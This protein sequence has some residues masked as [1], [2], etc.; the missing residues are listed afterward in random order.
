MTDRSEQAG[1]HGPVPGAERHREAEERRIVPP[2]PSTIDLHAHTSR[3]DGLLLPAELARQAAAVGVRL[4]AITDH[5]TLAGV[6]ELRDS[7]L[8]PAGLEILPG[9][10]INGVVRDRPELMESEVHVLGLGVNPDH[11]GLEAVLGQQRQARR[12]RFERM[13][14]R[15][16]DLG[17]AIDRALEALPATDEDDALGRPRLAR[18][19][20]A[21]DAATSVGDAFE[22]WLSRGRPAYVPRTGLSPIEA[23][24]AIRGAG[25]LPSLAHFAEAPSL[26]GVIEELRA[27]GLGGLEVYHRS[28]D[29]AT[30]EAVGQVARDLGLVATGGSDYHG[31]RET[32]AEAHATL[33]VP[34]SV[35]AA[36]RGALARPGIPA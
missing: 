6:R 28:F 25:G 10:E 14:A 32:Y 12:S 17:F 11:E 15:L 19:L 30:V 18:A 31:D 33:W 2:E 9:V 29:A 22:R 23:I 5:D 13:V 8:T 24:A 27:A 1:S 20:I 4:L 16:R 21:L 34:P 26:R 3:S 35:E 36:V 7:G